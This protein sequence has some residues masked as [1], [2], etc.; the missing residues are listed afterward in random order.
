[1]TFGRRDEIAEAVRE[2]E[3]RAIAPAELGLQGT[4]FDGVVGPCVVCRQVTDTRFRASGL[5]GA[6][7]LSLHVLCGARLI[8]AYR[9][10]LNGETP[11]FALPPE[12]LGSSDG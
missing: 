6:P 2:A 11:A 9:Q 1:M 10:L 8:R 5:P 7:M 3:S 4:G 12:L